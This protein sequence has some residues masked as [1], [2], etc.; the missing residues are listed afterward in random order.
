M[1]PDHSARIQWKP[2]QKKQ[3]LCIL[4]RP[5]KKPIRTGL[6][7]SSVEERAHSPEQNPQQQQQINTNKMARDMSYS[8]RN[9]AQPSASSLSFPMAIRDAVRHISPTIL[10][11]KR[12]RQ[13]P[14]PPDAPERCDSCSTVE[15][16]TAEP[17]PFR[18]QSPAASARS[19]FPPRLRPP[20]EGSGPSRPSTSHALVRLSAFSGRVGPALK[21]S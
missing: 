2:P 19:E 16:E 3:L 11:R 15:P 14:T 9:E 8:D 17:A 7:G 5:R 4:Q 10:L 1:V 21:S 12:V 6:G 13:T 18:P 20:H